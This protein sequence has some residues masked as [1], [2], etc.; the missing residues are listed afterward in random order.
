[1]GMT[2]TGL[3]RLDLSDHHDAFYAVVSAG[4][5]AECVSHLPR[6]EWLGVRQ[7]GR[8]YEYHVLDLARLDHPN[9]DALVIEHDYD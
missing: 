7:C 5:L 1:M 4:A 6:L 2:C 8:K 9:A 3:T